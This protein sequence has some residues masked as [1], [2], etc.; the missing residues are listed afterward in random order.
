MTKR[1][2]GTA[3]QIAGR[4]PAENATNAA[5]RKLLSMQSGGERCIEIDHVQTAPINPCRPSI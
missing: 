1:A 4:H 3:E 2:S 5:K